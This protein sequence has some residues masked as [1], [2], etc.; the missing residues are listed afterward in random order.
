MK[1]VILMMFITTFLFA[2]SQPGYSNPEGNPLINKNII[3]YFQKQI[4]LYSPDDNPIAQCG[5]Y[6]AGYLGTKDYKNYCDQWSVNE[7]K[8]LHQN[9]NI[10][11][12]ASIENLRDPAL[13]QIVIPKE[14]PGLP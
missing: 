9:L 2:C 14:K 11:T 12:K 10:T 6:Y 13:W 8:V 3:A 5:S 1:M 4:D 7:F